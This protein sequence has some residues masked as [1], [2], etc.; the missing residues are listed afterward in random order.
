MRIISGFRSNGKCMSVFRVVV[1]VSLM[2][3]TFL[4]LL[5]TDMSS[6]PNFVYNDF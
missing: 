3:V 2:I 4:Y 1:L 6:V 5:N